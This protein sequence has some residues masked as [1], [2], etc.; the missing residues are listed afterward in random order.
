MKK[1]VDLEEVAKQLGISLSILKLQLVNLY[2][3]SSYDVKNEYK[4]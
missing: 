2:S 4:Q 3:D 1:S